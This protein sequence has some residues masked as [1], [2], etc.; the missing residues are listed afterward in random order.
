MKEVLKNQICGICPGGCVVDVT[1]E[2]GKILRLD[3]SKESPYGAICLRGKHA[4]E[5]VYSEDRLLTPLIR[6]GPKGTDSFREAS[7]EEALDLVATSFLEI[8]EQY[9]ARSLISHA[10]RG[11]FEQ[12][13]TD[14]LTVANPMNK[15]IPAFFE[16][17]GSPNAANVG[18]LCYNSFGVFA[19]MSTLGIAGT[20]IT[21]DL[22]NAK[23]LVVWGANPAT[24]SPPFPFFALLRAKER[25]CR[26]ITV[27]HFMS[28]VAKRSEKAMLLRSGT[29]GAFVLG[30]LNYLIEHEWYDKD[31]VENYTVG[32][33]ELRTYAKQFTLEEVSKITNLSPDDIVWFAKALTEHKETA[34]M[35]YTGLEYSDSGVQT[36]RAVYILWA[37]LGLLDQEGALLLGTASGKKRM[38]AF[39]IA[40]SEEIRI[41]AKEYPLFDHL[42]GVSQFIEFP[43]A[44]LQEDPYPIKGLLNIGASM[45]TSYPNTLLYEEA[46]SKLDFFCTIDRYKTRDALFA[47]VVL[48]APTYFEMQSYAMYGDRIKRR[49]QV[50]APRGESRSDL[51]ILHEIAE[52]LGYGDLY[53][54]DTQELYQK[55]FHTAPEIQDAMIHGESGEYMLP[56]KTISF[57]KYE[58]G[59]LREDG[60]PGFPTPSGKFEIKSSLLEEFGYPGL[61]EYSEPKEGP[62]GNPELFKKY[63]LVLN[64]GTRI[65]TTFRS[66]FL[67]I[68]GLL[69]HQPHPQVWINTEEAKKR[70]IADDE[71]VIVFNDRGEVP[72]YAKVTDEIP[73][74]EVELNVG[75]GSIYQEESWRNAAANLLTDDG[76]RD[77]IS[78]FPIYKALLCDVKKLG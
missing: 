38:Q 31:F 22:K 39:D 23:T 55:A 14:F 50:I 66:Q 6:T 16:P 51:W 45:T 20:R 1:M 72:F 11:V 12:A 77:Y 44:V 47:D 61:P 78:G 13:T 10:G 7:W 52:R 34:V 33:E 63:P 9:G 48:P 59:G 26:I 42:L 19:P 62:I 57:R 76:H 30:I 43:K 18:S 2:D 49:D 41:G 64:T 60:K 35:M 67:N 24:N 46:L 32:F 5:I 70:G 21:P 8:K 4:A 56:K 15:Q 54:K 75:G 58:S 73:A 27:D 36:I 25:G 71:Q 40:P 74:G 69:K 17:L 3:P 53:P 29:D 28:D 65:Q 68:K 37:I